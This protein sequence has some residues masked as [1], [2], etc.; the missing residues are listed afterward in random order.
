[1]VVEEILTE[2]R[3]HGDSHRIAG[4]KRFGATSPAIGVGLPVLRSIARR[5]GHDHGLALAL[6]QTGIREA[7]ILASLIDEPEQVTRTQMGRWAEGF[8]SWEI[9]DQCCQN[10]FAHTASALDTAVEWIERPE[11]FVKRAGFV[12]V[13]VCAVRDKRMEDKDFA[14]LVPM[15]IAAADDD[16][17]YVRKG[18]SWALRQIGKR[19]APLHGRVLATISPLLDGDRRGIRWVA[20]DAARELNAYRAPGPRH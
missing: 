14:E 17:G 1:V 16:R 3:R 6:W 15:L 18:A 4:L 7:H 12:L 2:L 11:E 8:D 5:I 13:A 20:R 19:S 10:L 9:C